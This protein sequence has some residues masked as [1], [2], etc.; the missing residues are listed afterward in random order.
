LFLPLLFLFRKQ[1]KV[2][3]IKVKLNFTRGQKYKQQPVLSLDRNFI[4]FLIRPNVISIK[5][6]LIPFRANSQLRLEILEML[7]K[8]F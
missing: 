1:K 6:V 8:K 2:K 3:Q 7:H 5:I 4:F